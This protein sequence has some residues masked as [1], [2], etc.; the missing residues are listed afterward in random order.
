MNS[1]NY[2]FA[3]TQTEIEIT[4]S[5]IPKSEISLLQ[6]ILPQNIKISDHL[7]SKTSYLIMYKTFF[8]NK[9]IT[10]RMWGI[11]VIKVDWL[12]ALSENPRSFFVDL[13]ENISFVCCG[14]VRQSFVN[15]YT[16]QG[17]F[18]G[19]SLNLTT[20]FVLLGSLLKK[21]FLEYKKEN[22]LKTLETNLKDIFDTC[23]TNNIP[24]I[25]EDEV[26]EKDLS[27]YKREYNFL[28]T[29]TS[30]EN[31]L[32]N[33]KIFIDGKLNQNLYNLLKRTIIKNDGLRQ[34]EPEG[35]DIIVSNDM[36]NS[37]FYQYLLDCCETKTL[38]VKENY[39]IKKIKK[40]KIFA[41]LVFVIDKKIRDFQKVKSQIKALGGNIRRKI[42]STC[43]HIVSNDIKKEIKLRSIVNEEW[44]ESCM[45][46][47][48][49][50]NITN[51]LQLKSEEG[52]KEIRVKYLK[53]KEFLVQF[54]ALSESLKLNAK[55]KLDDL[56]I[57]YKE[58]NFLLSDCTH[59]IVG[60]LVYSEKLLCAIAQGTLI[61]S[62]DFIKSDFPSFNKFIFKENKLQK[63]SYNSM[64]RSMDYWQKR[65]K[66]KN[67]KVFENWICKIDD[68]SMKRV[69]ISGGA[70]ITENNDY[71][72]QFFKKIEDNK[73]GN[74]KKYPISYIFRYLLRVK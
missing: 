28:T 55:K 67:V 69:L 38:L 60:T 7:S 39:A 12:Y 24:I 42:D 43:T 5:M 70:K 6:Q 61:I 11:P 44:I 29:H 9:Y 33:L 36:E 26:Y 40:V 47:L 73:G 32:S 51:K 46:N 35:A 10:A 45:T 3:N 53:E 27:F 14:D 57:K 4:F 59:L 16:Q 1:Q 30:K 52:K 64:V 72:H 15:F 65:F 49:L 56:E 41:G 2:S 48:K 22:S 19:E 21:E 23:I 34:S 68:E 74:G 20:G 8:T 58:T 17:A 63:D 71:T 54:S 62:S 13:F 25:F 37:Y 18:L 50:K 31:I 66:T